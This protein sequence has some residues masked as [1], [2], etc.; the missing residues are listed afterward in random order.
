MCRA[1]EVVMFH[2]ARMRGLR[3]GEANSRRQGHAS[4]KVWGQALGH[5]SL[6]REPHSLQYFSC[7]VYK[8]SKMAQ[9]QPWNN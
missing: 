8:S 7:E 9:A 4:R 5:S 6:T 3:P 1:L 2:L